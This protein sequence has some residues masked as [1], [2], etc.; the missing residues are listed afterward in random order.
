MAC[1]DN[2]KKVLSFHQHKI[3]VSETHE[4]RFEQNSGKI[5]LEQSIDI[6]RDGKSN[7]PRV[8]H[9][10]KIHRVINFNKVLPWIDEEVPGGEIERTSAE[11]IESYWTFE[12]EQWKA[13]DDESL[14]FMGAV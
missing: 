11:T 7:N 5:A 10:D 4:W 9:V 12:S 14:A 8:S 1:L 13:F 6:V 2:S 3:S